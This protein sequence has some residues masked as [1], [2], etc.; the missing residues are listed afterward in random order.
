MLFPTTLLSLSILL[1]LVTLPLGI[2]WPNMIPS[3][4]VITTM[5]IGVRLILD[6]NQLFHENISLQRVKNIDPLTGALNR[7]VLPELRANIH[8]YIVMI[9]LDGFKIINDRFGHA[10]GDQVLTEFTRVVT[11]NLR[12][13]DL[14]IRFGGDEFILVLNGVPKTQKGYAEVVLILERIQEQYI[15][16]HPGIF[17][18]FSYGIAAMESNV[19]KTIEAADRQMYLMKE[20]RSVFRLG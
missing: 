12:Q 8:D 18:S 4:F 9:D 3:V 11:Q 7:N 5:L 6:Y 17:L 14:V 2:T 19:E 15:G 16:L 20:A 13:N 10:F 1:L